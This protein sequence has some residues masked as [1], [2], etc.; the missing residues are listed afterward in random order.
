MYVQAAIEATKDAGTYRQFHD[1][2]EDYS[3]QVQSELNALASAVDEIAD[4]CPDK[5]D[6]NEEPFPAPQRLKKSLQKISEQLKDKVC[7]NIS[8]WSEPFLTSEK[9]LWAK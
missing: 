1:A 4:N 2:H 5:K 9:S 7:G 3:V 6:H 8:T